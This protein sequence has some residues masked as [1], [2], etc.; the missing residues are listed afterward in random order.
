MATT[1]ADTISREFH[2]RKGGIDLLAELQIRTTAT[3][4][5]QSKVLAVVF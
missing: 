1:V 2:K 3:L 4:G 5:R